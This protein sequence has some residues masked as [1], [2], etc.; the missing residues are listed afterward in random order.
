MFIYQGRLTYLPV[1]LPD[2]ATTPDNSV[3]VRR[4]RLLV[5]DQCLV[6]MSMLHSE[7]LN[8]LPSAKSKSTHRLEVGFVVFLD[9]KQFSS[10]IRKITL[11]GSLSMVK[12]SLMKEHWEH[13]RF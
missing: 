11:L 10:K 8:I 7:E 13:P 3:E 1:Y 2:V 9:F 12:H 4:K 5:A 6:A